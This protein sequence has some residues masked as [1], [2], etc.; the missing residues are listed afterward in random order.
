MQI[1]N[2]YSVPV[3][4]LL[5]D[6]SRAIHLGRIPI[7]DGGI[8]GGIGGKEMVVLWLCSWGMAV[9][10]SSGRGNQPGPARNSQG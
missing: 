1:G 4:F 2:P 10:S 9:R 5:G 6:W 8:H 7:E 3:P